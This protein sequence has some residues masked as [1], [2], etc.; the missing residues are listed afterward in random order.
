MD[1]FRCDV[2]SLLP[3]QFWLDA[4]HAVDRIRPDILWLAESVDVRFLAEQRAAGLPALSDCELY[5]AFDITYDYDAWPIW[6]ATVAGNVPVKRYLEMLRYQE[7]MNP[8]NFVKLRFVEN[9]DETRI[10]K[11]ARNRDAAL[12]WTAFSAFNRGA[13]S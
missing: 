1:G 6:R 12:A 2:A 7:C 9:H 8:A 3:K 10:A 4:R 13:C 5:D 11:L